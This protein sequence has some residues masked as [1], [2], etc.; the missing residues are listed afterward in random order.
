MTRHLLLIRH[1]EAGPTPPGGTDHERPLAPFGLAQA[2][3]LGRLIAGGA[4]PAPAIVLTSDAERARQTWAAAAAAAGLAVEVHPA[5]DL[6]GGDV[7]DLI[8]ALR[9]LPDAAASAALVAHSPEV[10]L[11]ARS[12]PDSRGAGAAPLFGW[13]PATV[14]VVALDGPWSAFPDAARLVAVVGADPA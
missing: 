1:A 11:L 10:P 13:P 3:R 4:L 5:A 12:L 2:E 8:E 6:Y 9:A 7:D 14:G